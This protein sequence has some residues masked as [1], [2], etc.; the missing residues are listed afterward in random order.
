MTIA[1]ELTAAD[2][3]ARAKA[4]A[5]ELRERAAEIEQLRHLPEDIVEKLRAT[6]IYRAGF[7][8]AWGGPDLSSLQELEVIEALS[9]GDASAA[10]S[11]EVCAHTGHFAR[12]LSPVAA[13]EMF[14]HLDII[15]AGA[16]FPVGRAEMAPGGYRLS[17]RWTFGSGVTTCDWVISG[18]FVFQDGQPFPGSGSHDSRLFMVRREDV[19]TMD[20]WETT[21]LAGTGSCD[22]TITDVF[23]P[24]DHA[25]VFSELRDPDCRRNEPETFMRS[26]PGVPLG[27]A[28]AALDHVRELA[29]TRRYPNGDRWADNRRVQTIIAECEADYHASRQG[30][31]GALTRLEEVLGDNGTLDDLT[32]DERAVLPLSRLHAFRTAR[33]IVTRLYDLLQT[34]SIHRASPM[35]RWLRDTTTMCQH[36]FAQ[37]RILQSGGAHLL[38]GAPEFGLCLGIAR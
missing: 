16:L 33:S 12:Y 8:H 4:L 25:L 17:G 15:T 24:E 23:V 13:K 38:G 2:I 19:T 35:D 37:E 6:G 28:R 34:A 21:G 9:Y 3:L 1:P 5:P 14:P 36:L 20:N 18:A 10:W 26:L 11:A 30:V 22:Y 27:V 7:S 31:R 29:T 32:V